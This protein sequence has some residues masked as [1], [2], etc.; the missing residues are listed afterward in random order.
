MPMR[1]ICDIAPRQGAERAMPAIL[2]THGGL[3]NQLF[4]VL[5]GRLF[6]EKF[7]LNLREVHDTRYKHAF[8]RS[9][10]MRRQSQPL[11][12]H[13]T[14][15]SALRIPK[16]LQR[17]FRGSEQP[18]WLFGTAYLDGYFQNPASYAIFDSEAIGRQLRALGSELSI[19]P[20]HINQCLVHLRLGDFFKSRSHA[21]DH[22]V[23]RLAAV[24]PNSSVMT[25][26]E[27]LLAEDAIAALLA[28]KGCS[29]VPTAGLPSEDVLRLMASY[30]R[31]DANDSTLVFWA[32]VLGGCHAPLRDQR[33]R[34]TQ[35]LFL[36]SRSHN[37]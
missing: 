2:R 19:Q 14:V 9:A 1:G 18:M 20:A 33:L 12:P 28:T 21:R 15:V 35:E 23:Q 13:E 4:Q 30:R 8:Q 25:N 34:A 37:A 16:V 3:G 10:A 5:Y 31:L 32:S 24:A 36:N 6:A 27:E 29:L 7:G 26:D 17:V 22:V 11:G